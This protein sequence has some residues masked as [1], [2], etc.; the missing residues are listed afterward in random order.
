MVQSKRILHLTTWIF[1]IKSD[2]ENTKRYIQFT[3]N[4][5]SK[6]LRYGQYRLTFTRMKRRFRL[7]EEESLVRSSA[8]SLRSLQ[9]DSHW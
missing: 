1:A 8:T 6:A 2:E 5:W 9:W 4:S 7:K 3:L